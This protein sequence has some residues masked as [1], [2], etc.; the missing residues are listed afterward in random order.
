MTAPKAA[1]KTVACYGCVHLRYRGADS[2]KDRVRFSGGTAI[3]LESGGRAFDPGRYACG[4]FGRAITDADEVPTELEAGCK[5][6][7]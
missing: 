1:G 5:E 6:R 3:P 2:F 7:R 4:K